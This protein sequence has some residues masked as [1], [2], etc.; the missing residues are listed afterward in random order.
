M[1]F[2]SIIFDNVKNITEKHLFISYNKNTTCYNKYNKTL[3][4]I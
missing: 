1:F 4:V 3:R 2:I